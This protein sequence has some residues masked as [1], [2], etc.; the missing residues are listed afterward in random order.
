MVAD[1]GGE[2]LANFPPVE[3]PKWDEWKVGAVLNGSGDSYT[4]IKAWAMNHTAW[5]A[6]VQKDISYRYYFDV[7]E[8]LEAGYSVDIVKV[9]GK[10]QQ[11]KEGEQGYGTVSGPYKYEGDPTGNTYYAEV[12]FEDGRAIQP[13]GQSEHRDEVQFRVSIPDAIDGTPTKGAWDPANEWPFEGVTATDSLKDPASY[14]KHIPMYVNGALV[15]GEEPDGTKAVPGAD[16]GAAEP[17]VVTPTEPVVDPTDPVVEP[18]DEPTEPVG[19]ILYGDANCDGKVTIADS[20]AILQSLGNPDK[21][22]LSAQ[23]AANADV[24]GESGITADD[25]ITILKVDA[26]LLDAKELPLKK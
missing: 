26:K 17:P 23:G 16:I 3:T 25:A 19:D 10:A 2:K 9:E 24:N 20:T 1:K 15:W 12:K 21:Y 4:E 13:T 11:Y 14:N 5:P 7:S 22:A 18:T 8:L 6:R